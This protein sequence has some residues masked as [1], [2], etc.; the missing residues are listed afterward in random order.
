MNSNDEGPQFEKWVEK[1]L[2]LRMNA[3]A[4]VTDKKERR[5]PSVWKHDLAAEE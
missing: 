5:T 4:I 3:E 1:T 2:D